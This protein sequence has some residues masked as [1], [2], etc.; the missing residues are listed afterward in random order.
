MK[1]VEVHDEMI[2][3]VKQFLANRDGFHDAN[4]WEGLF[5]YPWKLKGHPYGYAILDED[6]IVAFAGTIFSERLI[7]GQKR[8]CCNASTW[9]VEEEYRP[10]MLAILVLN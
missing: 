5:N 6:R 9:F 7:G 3:A 4:G 2:G 1:I 8:I 10:R